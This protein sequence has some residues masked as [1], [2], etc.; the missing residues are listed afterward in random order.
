MKVNGLLN[1]KFLPKCLPV[2]LFSMKISNKTCGLA[3]AAWKLPRRYQLTFPITF[4]TKSESISFHQ[5]ADE[6]LEAL[7]DVIG[8]IESATVEEVDASLSVSSLQC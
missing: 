6:T 7:Y 2:K 3:T 1:I 8:S 4:T 5:S